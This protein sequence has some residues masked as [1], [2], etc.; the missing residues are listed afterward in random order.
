[1]AGQLVFGLVK[2]MAQ[3]HGLPWLAMGFGP[4]S[5]IGQ[6]VCVPQPVAVALEPVD[7]A[8]EPVAGTDGG[9]PA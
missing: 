4:A 2:L 3:T 6:R 1:M 8:L 9:S 7:V 5:F